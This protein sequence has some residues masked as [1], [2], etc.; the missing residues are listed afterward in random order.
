ML[1]CV[2]LVYERTFSKKENAN[3]TCESCSTIKVV[4]ANYGEQ[5]K[6][7]YPLAISTRNTDCVTTNAT[8]VVEN[9]CN[10]KTQCLFDVQNRNFLKTTCRESTILLVRYMCMKIP[11][12][13]Q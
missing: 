9:R 3:L 12:T 5:V 6:R 13:F 10:G 8:S 1:L 7:K 4:W 11:G 2:Y